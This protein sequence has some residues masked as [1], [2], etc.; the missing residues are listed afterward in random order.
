MLSLGLASAVPLQTKT[1]M[2]AR[3]I[4]FLSSL[5]YR[6]VAYPDRTCPYCKNQDTVLVG[7]KFVVMQVRRCSGCGLM[8]RWPKDSE[9]TNR[10][11]YQSRYR[12]AQVTDVP[13]PAEMPGLLARNF[14]GTPYDRGSVIAMF[15]S[16][17]PPPARV[18]DFGCSWGYAAHQ[19]KQAGYAVTGFEI[20]RSRAAFGRAKLGIEII[21]SYQALNSLPRHSFDVIYS[22]HVLEH[23][24]VLTGKFEQ[25]ARL[26]TADGSLVIFTP[27]CGDGLGNLRP[28]WKP[29]VGEKHPMAF[30]TVFFRQVLP[31]H[32]F[33]VAVVTTPYS[34]QELLAGVSSH[35]DDGFEILLSAKRCSPVQFARLYEERPILK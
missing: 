8:F 4:R 12:E 35:R 30:D 13:V 11:F 10:R 7:R 23:L 24:P 22:Y 9:S 21:D 34:E 20:S 1:L 32:G 15:K 25:L 33:R 27:N 16:V 17:K 28:G 26:L 6:S 19:L 14:S 5:I 29:L 3:R 18:L 31:R 2:L